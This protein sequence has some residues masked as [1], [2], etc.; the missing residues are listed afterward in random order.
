M[1]EEPPKPLSLKERMALKKKPVEEYHF[2][3]T[4]QV[5][6]PAQNMGMDGQFNP[7]AFQGMQGFGDNQFGG[8]TSHPLYNINTKIFS[9][10]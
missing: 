5:Q 9:R 6:P 10:H 7:M 8:N 2:A 3:P 4:A 1:S